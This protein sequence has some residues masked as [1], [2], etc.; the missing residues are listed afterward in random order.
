MSQE[1]LQL[2]ET[3]FAVPSL[4]TFTKRKQAERTLRIS[5]ALFAAVFRSNLAAIGVHTLSTG[6]IIE[7][8]DRLCEFSG[9]KREEVIG[10]TI[11]ELETWVDVAQRDAVMERVRATGSVTDAEVRLRRR[12]GEVRDVLISIERLDVPDEP[13]PVL[14]TMFT[15]ITERKRSG[16]RFK[17]LVESNAQGVIFWNTSASS[18]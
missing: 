15:D 11:F 16:E 14:V 8:N 17:R 4:L 7:V 1:P 10:K 13:E 12:N 6:R 5:Q 3:A 2:I 9:W 18:I